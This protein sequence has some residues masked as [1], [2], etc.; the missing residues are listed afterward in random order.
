MTRPRLL[1]L[2]CGAGG[3]AMGY[4]RAGFDVVGVD[5]VPQPTYPFDFVEADAI[6]YPLDGFD[7]VHASPP[8][9]R[10]STMGNRARLPGPDLL[11]IVFQRFGPL[12]VPW[13]VENVHGARRYMPN[14]VVLTGGMFGLRV[15]RPRLFL[16]NVGLLVPPP[17]RPP[18]DGVGVYGRVPDGRRLFT[19][20]RN[21]G[22]YHAPRG[23][24]AAR[25]A[26][27]MPWGDWQGVKNAV[28]P[29]YTEF[30]GEQIRAFVGVDLTPCYVVVPRAPDE[31]ENS[32]SRDYEDVALF[33]DVAP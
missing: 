26:M 9:Q 20:P 2:F 23:L 21:S 3:A 7:A 16:S 19:L 4:H 27:G 10:Y 24:D 12:R 32:S 11:R 15:H 17:V 6:T 18:D 33:D 5:V 1:D 28:P 25:A 22:T 14:A 31:S 13:I 8:C 30:L 29:A